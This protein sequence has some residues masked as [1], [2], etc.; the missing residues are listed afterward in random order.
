MLDQILA[1]TDTTAR[2]WQPFQVTSP[3]GIPFAGYLCR[4]ESEKLGLLAITELA[5]EERLE[6]I[7]S[8]PKIHYPYRKDRD[9]RPEVSISVPINIVDAR[10]TEKLDGTAIIFYGLPDRQGNVLEVIPRTRLQPI[11]APSRWGDW[12]KLLNEVLPDR[13]GVEEAVRMQRVVLAFELWGYRNPHM[14]SYET[15]LALTLHTA[16][17][18]RKPVSHRLLSDF[19]ARYGFDLAKSVAV[20]KPDA[21]GLA[22]AYRRLQQEMETRNQA[23]GEDKFLEEGLILVLSTAETA[24]Y[25]KCKPPTIEEIHWAQGAGIGKYNI[26]HTLY[27]MAE[28]GYDFQTG[29]VA[30]VKSELETDFDADAVVNAAELIER[31]YQEFVLE[32]QQR[33]WLKQLVDDS[34]LDV[35]DL[36]NLMR[37][38]SQHYAK[39]QMSWVYGTVKSLYGIER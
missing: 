5:G 35:H 12:N 14:I 16:I 30:D 4:Q 9:G 28:N 19:A 32:Q 3:G 10:F 17:R 33:Q 1:I 13:S 8:M 38:L 27:K 2:Y 20:V 24:S 31:V 25:Y 7:Y 15:P 18:H 39:R 22:D 34:G 37:Y 29:T 26:E 6:F 23:A 21:E 36:P 11:L